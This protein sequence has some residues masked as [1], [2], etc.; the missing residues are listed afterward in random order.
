[1]ACE[2]S[3]GPGASVRPVAT[4][5]WAPL[6]LPLSGLRHASGHA[7][8]PVAGW[9]TVTTRGKPSPRPHWPQRGDLLG[10]GQNPR[11]VR[12]QHPE[13]GSCS[14]EGQ[15]ESSENRPAGLAATPSPCSLTA[16]SSLSSLPDTCFPGARGA[17]RGWKGP[18]GGFPRVCSDSQPDTQVEPAAS[19]LQRETRPWEPRDSA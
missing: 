3:E 9:L 17:R 5:G 8:S 14:L 18:G 7:A 10:V 6:L 15:A 13:P 2:L 19:P 11:R 16:S 4:L 1:M 12:D